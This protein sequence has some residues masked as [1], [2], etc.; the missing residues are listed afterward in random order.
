MMRASRSLFCTFTSAKRC[1][2]ARV[3]RKRLKLPQLRQVGDP[4]LADALAQQARE[5]RIGLQQPAP[6]RHAVGL[7]AE[8]FRP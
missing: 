5:L 4:G 8:F 7:V 3:I 2:E 1:L 6:R